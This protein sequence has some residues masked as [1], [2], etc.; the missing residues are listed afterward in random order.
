M[1]SRG[2]E[3]KVPCKITSQNIDKLLAVTSSISLLTHLRDWFSQFSVRKM[4]ERSR[5]NV[6]FLY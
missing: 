2:N 3:F 6:T 4:I 5:L 1:R